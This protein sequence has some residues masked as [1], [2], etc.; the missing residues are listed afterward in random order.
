M[1]FLEK[2]Q[3]TC[4]NFIEKGDLQNCLKELKAALKQDTSVREDLILILSSYNSLLKQEQLLDSTEYRREISK[5]AKSILVLVDSLEDRDVSE[6]VFIETLLIICNPQKRSDM[7][8]FFGKRYFPNAEFIN[9]GEVLPKGI[10]DV[11]ILEDESNIINQTINNKG[12]E[13]PTEQNKNR[14]EQM[15][16]YLDTSD[17][18]FLYIGNRFT[19]GY[20]NRVYFSNSRFSIYARLK[21]LLDYLKY[22]SK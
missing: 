22:Y 7:E 21:E 13:I 3:S 16:G 5:I 9:Y 8:A 12:T 18:Y 6:G 20:E 11:I 14:R 15:K 17:A 10:Y 2:T 4:N 19:L 1:T